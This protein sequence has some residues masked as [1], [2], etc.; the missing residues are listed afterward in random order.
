MTKPVHRHSSSTVRDHPTA[1][2]AAAWGQTPFPKG[3]QKGFPD[4]QLRCPRVPSAP[5]HKRPRDGSFST[6]QA[7]GILLRSVR[8]THRVCQ[9]AISPFSGCRTPVSLS[10]PP[11]LHSRL[12]ELRLPW[13]QV[14]SCE[15]PDL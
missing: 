7:V 8:N 15:T 1:M 12:L 11:F 14:W 13:L 6:A 9:P 2:R 4:P 10:G 3:L 5:G